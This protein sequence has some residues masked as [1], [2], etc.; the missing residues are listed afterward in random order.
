MHHF[1]LATLRKYTLEKLGKPC[2]LI[3][4]AATRFGTNTLVGERLLKLKSSLQGACTDEDYVNKKYVDKGNS[5]EQTGTGRIVRS[6]KGGTAGKLCPDN[7]SNG[8]WA[9]VA[10]KLPC[11]C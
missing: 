5:E 6:N 9:R 11:P 1:P 2:E 8:F 10:C 7:R 3:K 4:A